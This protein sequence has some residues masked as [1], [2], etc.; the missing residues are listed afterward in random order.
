MEWFNQSASADIHSMYLAGCCIKAWVVLRA[1]SLYVVICLSGG[2]KSY[3]Q[4][5]F[6][7]QFVAK[8]PII[9]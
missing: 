2:Y 4:R 7:V 8:W 5:K 9:V 1:T 6:I 3:F